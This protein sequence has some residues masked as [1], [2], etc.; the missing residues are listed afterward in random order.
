MIVLGILVC[1]LGCG[2]FLAALT[3]KYR[4]FR[5]VVPFLMKTW[6]FVTPTILPPHSAKYCAQKL[7]T[8]PKPW[9]TSVWPSQ[10]FWRLRK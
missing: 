9:M 8:L 10:S 3:V 7:P 1:G 5:V 6:L 2:I 4:D